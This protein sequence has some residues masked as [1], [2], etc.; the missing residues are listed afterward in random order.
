[1][2]SSEVFEGPPALF[3]RGFEE[4]SLPCRPCPAFALLPA[5]FALAVGLGFAEEVRVVRGAMATEGKQVMSER[6][7]AIEYRQMTLRSRCSKVNT[8]KNIH[9]VIQDSY[10][11]LRKDTEAWMPFQPVRRSPKDLADCI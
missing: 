1:M 8:P 4:V 10:D 5:V 9:V 2:N 6:A 7:R 3:D 11:G